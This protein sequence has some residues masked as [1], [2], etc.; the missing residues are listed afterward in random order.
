[1]TNSPICKSHFD[2]KEYWAVACHLL[3][4]W[5]NKDLHSLDFVRPHKPW[6][7]VQQSHYDIALHNNKLH[8][9]PKQQLFTR[10]T[11][12]PMGW[13]KLNTD[14]ASKSRLKSGCGGL[15]RDFR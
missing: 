5:R 12:P 1:M 3:W 4:F 2:W 8:D 6:I 11:T 7:V 15:L 9:I 13:V 14:G 10:W